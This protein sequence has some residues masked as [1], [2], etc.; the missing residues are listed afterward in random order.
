MKNIFKVWVF[1]LILS[2][3][4]TGCD[5]LKDVSYFDSEVGG[6]FGGSRDGY[7]KKLPHNYCFRVDLASKTYLFEYP[8]EDELAERTPGGLPYDETVLEGHF[9]KGFYTMERLALCEE[10]EDDTLQYITFDFVSG[11]IQ[12]HTDVKEVYERLQID[13]DS[14]IEW[15]Q[16]DLI[17][18][19]SLCNTNEEIR[20]VQ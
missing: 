3:L 4:V 6:N 7:Y 12:Y 14:A 10:L 5:W 15:L 19:F 9:I 17:D 20:A 18:W 8:D 16:L 11:E 1:V 2:V 13:T